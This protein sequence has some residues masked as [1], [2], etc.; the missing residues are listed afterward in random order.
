M[1]TLIF[2]LLL[3]I[4]ADTEPTLKECDGL[5]TV[6]GEKSK[7]SAK[8][9][10]NTNKSSQPYTHVSL[11]PLRVHTGRPLQSPVLRRGH[12]RSFQEP[13]RTLTPRYSPRQMMMLSQ[14]PLDGMN[15]LNNQTMNMAKRRL[16]SQEAV[17]NWASASRGLPD[18][19]FDG[20]E[21]EYR[22]LGRSLLNEVNEPSAFDHADQRFG[23]PSMLCAGG[24][25]SELQIS[26]ELFDLTPTH[27]FNASP[28][29]ANWDTHRQYFDECLVDRT[30]S[31]EYRQNPLNAYLHCPG[32]LKPVHLFR[33]RSRS[34]WSVGMSISSINALPALSASAKS[35]LTSCSQVANDSFSF[36]NNAKEGSAVF[37]VGQLKFGPGVLGYGAGGTVV[38]DGEFHGRPVAVKRILK[39]FYDMAAN[40]KDI[41]I[42]SDEH[43]NLVRL[44]AV[45]ED[46]DF[47]FLALERCKMSLADF[48]T[49][50]E[51]QMALVRS[52]GLPPSLAC[53]HILRG[54][55][56]GLAALHARGVVHRD[57]KP[58]NVLMTED[59]RA[60]LSDMGLCRRM[61]PDQTSF[62][63]LG[64]GGSS[65]WQAPEQLIIRDGGAARQTKA[66][67]IFSLG[68]VMYHCISAGRHPFGESSYKRDDNILKKE[69]HLDVLD[70]CPE[71]MD[72]ITTMLEK[73]PGRRPTIDEVI[74]HPFWWN[75]RQ[76]LQFLIELSDR[77]ENEDRQED[78]TLIRSFESVASKAT[79]GNW[80]AR[81][82]P[83]LVTN[84]GQYRKYTFTSL[85]DLLRVVRNKHNH[86]RELPVDLRNL[87]GPVPEGYYGYALF[88]V[89]TGRELF[90]VCAG[91]LL[92]DFLSC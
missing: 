10:K 25:P 26:E 71:A 52:D 85:R 43:P 56:E 79:G 91:T 30:N 28:I 63:S 67:D 7:A 62:F 8:P 17:C 69:P 92:L 2:G 35:S 29:H 46:K 15:D 90:G 32:N 88:V 87:M 86:F 53:L 22:I 40:E 39:A 74:D 19:L 48:V 83:L 89:W 49:S 1:T 9:G 45:E 68:C 3:G 47:V 72:L 23:R 5:A 44:F 82:D 80:G 78:K 76:K 70:S 60:K 75:Q 16:P 6:R 77:M 36:M 66:M 73:D 18:S 11:P 42:L 24:C 4:Q 58:H 13:K 27:A 38:F 65:G 12:Y 55:C 51:G 50:E 14:P 31:I 20:P 21:D 41:L 81:L 64:S 34:V 59:G 84:L 57:L 37:K 54:V 33:H 61:V